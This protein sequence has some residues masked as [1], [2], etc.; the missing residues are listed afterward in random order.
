MGTRLIVRETSKSYESSCQYLCEHAGYRIWDLLNRDE[1]PIQSKGAWLKQGLQACGHALAKLGQLRK[2][3]HI[4]MIGNYFS[5]FMLLLNKLH[6]IHPNK[7]Y[8]WGFFIHGAKAQRVLKG[9]FKV[10]YSKNVRFVIF[11]QFEKKLYPQRFGLEPEAFISLPYG[12]WVNS[13]PEDC[14]PRNGKDS[15]YFAGGYSNRDYATLLKAWEGIKQKLVIIGSKNNADLLAYT[16]HPTNPFV[17]VMLDTTPEVFEQTMR[18]AKACVM[19]FKSNTGASGQTVALKCMRM[20]IVIIASYTDTMTEYIKNGETGYL[21][22]DFLGELPRVV[23][24]LET[25]PTAFR[26]MTEKQY[27]FFESTFSYPVITKKMLD[28][29]EE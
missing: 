14:A 13:P 15:Y 12:D 29:F 10:T 2:A 3:D 28:V 9:L 19:P 6:I 22:R 1:T 4:I 20:K 7:L 8:W 16:Q 23:Q 27:A 18:G 11:S 24:S 26:R 17:Q 21:L 25:D 5:T